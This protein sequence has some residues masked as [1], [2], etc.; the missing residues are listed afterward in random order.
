M[1]RPV[2]DMVRNVAWALDCWSTLRLLDKCLS[3]SCP[4]RLLSRIVLR[5]L[6][7]ASPLQPPSSINTPASTLYSTNE[8]KACT[9]HGLNGSSRLRPAPLPVEQPVTST[10][11]RLCATCHITVTI[12]QR[13]GGCKNIYYCSKACQTL[14]WATHKTFCK[15]FLESTAP[16]ASMRCALLFSTGAKGHFVWM[17]YGDDGTPLDVAK[18][19]PRYA[20]AGYQGDCVS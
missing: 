13:C 4:M 7:L 16:R 14:K 18:C 1:L 2:S 12:A 5:A 9:Y 20:K 17:S 19:F 15:S 3:L 11:P 10:S 6:T 8:Y